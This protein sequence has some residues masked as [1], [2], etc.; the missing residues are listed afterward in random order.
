MDKLIEKYI[1]NVKISFIQV[2]ILLNL[3]NCTHIHI[4]ICY[5]SIMKITLFGNEVSSKYR[6]DMSNKHLEIILKNETL[7]IFNKQLS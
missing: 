3:K 1:I 2:Q 4:C 6:S 5:N 7:A